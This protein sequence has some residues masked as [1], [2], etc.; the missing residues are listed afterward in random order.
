MASGKESLGTPCNATDFGGANCFVARIFD[1][2]A[3]SHSELRS[4]SRARSAPM[5]TCLQRAS[6]CLRENCCM[7]FKHCAEHALI[8]AL[9]SKAPLEILCCL[10]ACPVFSFRMQFKVV[11]QKT[12]KRLITQSAKYQNSADNKNLSPPFHWERTVTKNME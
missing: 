6:L 3:L 9:Q 7:L 11:E 10:A 1:L 2:R 8:R 4:S 12:S 5:Q